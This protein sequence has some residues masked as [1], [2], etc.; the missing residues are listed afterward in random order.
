MEAGMKKQIVF[1]MGTIVLIPT[2][3]MAIAETNAVPEPGTAFLIISG[4]IG[5]AAMRKK[6]KK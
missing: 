3:A 4:L 2:M 6:Y 5:L 1:L